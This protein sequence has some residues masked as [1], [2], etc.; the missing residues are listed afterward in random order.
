[1]KK[2]ITILVILII[3]VVAGFAIRY[4]FY[5]TKN[6]NACSNPPMEDLTDGKISPNGQAIDFYLVRR[7]FTG[8]VKKL[9]Q[10][11]ELFNFTDQE[12][13]DG[14]NENTTNYFEAG[15]YIEGQYKGYKR[16]IAIRQE[17]G[18]R[19]TLIP[20]IFATLDFKD[21]VFDAGHGNINANAS[22]FNTNKVT[23][24]DVL[25]LETIEQIPIND[26]FILQR[27]PNN[28]YEQN[29]AVTFDPKTIG[30]SRG[31]IYNSTVLQNDFNEKNALASNYDFLKF[32]SVEDTSGDLP[33]R[34]SPN[35]TP[36]QKLAM[37]ITKKYFSG[38]S[39]VI[40]L[41]STGVPWI[42]HL[43][44]KTDTPSFVSKARFSDYAGLKFSRN[45]A[46]ID[47]PTFE[48]Y[49]SYNQ[50]CLMPKNSTYISK[51]T[52]DDVVKIGE[53]IND[54]VSIYALENSND[55]IFKL[56]YNSR[57]NQWYDEQVVKYESL[58]KPTLQEYINKYP[59]LFI[60]DPW[61]RY[62]IMQEADY[63]YGVPCA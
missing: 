6:T 53:T 57:F 33:T 24:K 45:Q 25:G 22:V 8:S 43:A 42:Y 13:R 28:A 19:V 61:G 40:V 17:S 51:I 58:K 46:N 30:T 29:I 44:I 1:M 18:K 56:V 38:S 52:D 15:E 10:K 55:P 41:D 60:K 49:L 23:K 32:Y 31:N 26:Q 27:E 47:V 35:E 34:E 4:R 16:V 2:T 36:E 7:I 62:L 12:K 63:F 14:I 39:K 3:T 5:G 9:D 48:T 37:E 54:P 20:Y 50:G 59:L 21:Y 11:L